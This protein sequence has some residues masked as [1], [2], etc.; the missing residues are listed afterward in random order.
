MTSRRRAVHRKDRNHDAIADIAREYGWQVVD[1]SGAGSGVPDLLLYRYPDGYCLV[2]VK[3]GAAA[4]TA[5]QERFKARYNIP[6]LYVRS[7][8]EAEAVLKE[9]LKVTA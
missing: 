4:L 2:E 7:T 6:V 3:M 1:L 8:A 9:A 5:A